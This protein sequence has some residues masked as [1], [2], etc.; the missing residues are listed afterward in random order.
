MDRIVVF[1]AGS[2]GGSIAEVLAK[3][4][5][6]TIVDQDPEQLN[7]LRP[8]LDARFIAGD[9]QT[10]SILT[11]AGCDEADAILAV[12]STDAVNLSVCHICN[13]MFGES[14]K[15]TRIARIRDR[16][17]SD[18][19]EL[20]DAF[21]VSQS[22]NTEELIAEAV[23]NVIEFVGARKVH[24]F[25]GGKTNIMLVRVLPGDTFIGKNIASWEKADPDLEFRVIAI[26]RRDEIMSA[27]GE[28]RISEGDDLLIV[29][30]ANDCIHAVN[31]NRADTNL[32]S[33]KVFIGGGGTIGEAIAKR[34][35]GGYQVTLIEPDAARCAHLMQNLG[36]TLVD[37]GDPTDASMLRGEDIEHAL[38]YCAVT[39]Q[40]E[41]NIMSALLAKQLGCSK[42]AVLVNRNAY[43]QVLLDHEMDTVISP[44]EITV[45]TLLRAIGERRRE[46]IH[47][48]NEDGAHLLEF[49]VQAKSAIEGTIAREVQWPDNVIPCAFGR[50]DNGGFKVFMPDSDEAIDEGDRGIVFLTDRDNNTLNQILDLPFYA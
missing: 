47:A 3:E 46:Q 25:F 28:T 20:L 18:N 13:I 41:V 19:R 22:Y 48:L 36:S 26:H 39:E 16:E 10:P 2:F 11:R 6:V 33:R 24:R 7:V 15:T 50:P 49:S 21:G 8:R 32:D 43:Q 4:H 29:S 1:G 14:G 38:Y 42:T 9:A 44:S 27:S 5:L 17:I 12:T 40:D 34:L 35:E 31:H 30:R 23:E 37:N 45:G